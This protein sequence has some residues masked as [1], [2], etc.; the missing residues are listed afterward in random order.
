[1][2]NVVDLLSGISENVEICSFFIQNFNPH[3]IK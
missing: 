3:Y 2:F 1:M